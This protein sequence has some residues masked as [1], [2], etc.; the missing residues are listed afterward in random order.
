MEVGVGLA[1]GGDVSGGAGVG[2]AEV[3]E[4]DLVLVV[5][6]DFGD[7]GAAAGEV[8]WGELALEDGVL[9]VVAEAAEGAEDF[10]EAL[11]VGDVVGDEVGVAHGASFGISA[12]LWGKVPNWDGSLQFRLFFAP[13]MTL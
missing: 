7:F 13:G 12:G 11:V 2:R 1:D 10:A 3:D 8:A 5:V 4:E 6:D 9:E